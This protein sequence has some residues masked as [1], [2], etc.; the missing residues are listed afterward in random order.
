L[1]AL[2]ANAV[3]GSAT[4]E[5]YRYGGEASNAMPIA[6]YRV[7][8]DWV[9]GTGVDFN[10]PP[11]YLADGAT[12]NRASPATPWT[13][14]GGDFDPTIVGQITLPASQVTGWVQL[15]AT[16]AVRA[17]VSGSQPNHGLLLRPLDG[18]YTYHYYYSRNC[19]TASLR[20]RLVVTYTVGG[21]ATPT[22]TVSPTRTPTASPTATST[23]LLKTYLPLVLKGS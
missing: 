10:P 9:E 7:T 19:G 2:P 12:W 3:I 18:Q 1:S 20:P 23:P 14:A 8:R 17:W 4:V 16:A 15:D 21:T 11:G 13:T 5:L 22:A 6:L